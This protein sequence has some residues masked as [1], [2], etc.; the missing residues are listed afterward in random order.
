MAETGGAL[1]KLKVPQ[2]PRFVCE[3]CDMAVYLED[4]C[5]QCDFEEYRKTL[6][7][8]GNKE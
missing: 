2:R 7:A 1:E 8:S 4:P 3:G 5:P 6:R